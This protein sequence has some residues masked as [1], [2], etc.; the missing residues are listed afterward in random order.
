MN[1]IGGKKLLLF[2]IIFVF[3]FF[4]HPVNGDGDIFHHLLSGKFIT[5]HLQL[6]KIDE[7][8][9]T[10]NG[11]PWIANAWGTDVIYYILYSALGPIGISASVALQA[12]IVFVL[13]Y[14]LLKEYEINEKVILISLAFTAAMLSMRWPNRPELITYIFVT[15]ILLFDK[16]KSQ[17]PK[18]LFAFP[19]LFFIWSIF[20]GGSVLIGFL[21]L[22]LICIKQFFIDKYKISRKSLL[23]YIAAFA[24]LIASFL[25]GYGYKTI[26][27]YFFIPDITKA[28][29]EWRGLLDNLLNNTPMQM[30]MEQYQIAIFLLFIAIFLFLAVF[31]N[32]QIIKFPFISILSLSLITPFLAMRN[33]P[34][35]AIL[36]LPFFAILLNR[37]FQVR[38]SNVLIF[39]IVVLSIIALFMAGWRNAHGV[40]KDEKYF[41]SRLIAFLS[42]NHIYGNVFSDQQTS[43]YIS[44]ELYPKALVY[45]DTR[46]ELYANTPLLTDLR[47]LQL[48]NKNI[49][50]VLDKYHVDIIIADI[51]YG[52]MYQPI[53]YSPK[54]SLIYVSDRYYVFIDS[55]K[56]KGKY[57][58]QFTAIDPFTANGS[59]PEKEKQAIEEYTLALS[60]NPQSFNI[61]FLLSQVLLSK[62]KYQDVIPIAESMKIPFGPAK[63]LL[64]D[65]KDFI[66]AS[67]NLNLNNCI[68]AKKYINDYHKDLI[69]KFILNP[70][71]KLAGVDE[72]LY[73]MYYLKCER[74]VAKAE[75]HLMSFLADNNIPNYLKQNAQNFYQ[76]FVDAN[77]NLLLN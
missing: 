29:G 13:L 6:P 28:Q 45:A 30:L 34:L 15:A 68:N 14:F 52:K 73:M 67:A 10:V 64:K 23:F 20:Y 18:L 51:T 8:T 35:A 49:F 16:L 39:L 3:F 62:N 32:K 37:L 60:Q 1:N 71:K 53:L 55:L 19:P 40:G 70:F 5:E 63:L 56:A 59:K 58:R 38:K 2:I 65:R 31:L 27:Y 42:S 77:A 43:P 12:V 66:L 22:S 57:M 17:Q 46:D 75:K 74:D 54:W 72:Q 7:Y 36:T 48:K 41:P 61:K 21:L 25:N 69:H 50:T 24:S 76:Q 44:Y 9:F 11:K 47:D 33:M 4:L 26:F